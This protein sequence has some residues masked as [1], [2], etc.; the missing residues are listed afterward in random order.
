MNIR[1]VWNLVSNLIK[2][3][4]MIRFLWQARDSKGF[5]KK[6]EKIVII[7]KKCCK[8]YNYSL[9]FRTNISQRKSN[10]SIYTKESERKVKIL[11]KHNPDV[12]ISTLT[13]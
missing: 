7:N 3:S 13:A 5:T 8:G 9:C 11:H 6:V 12:Q 10:L 2:K 4:L 1:N